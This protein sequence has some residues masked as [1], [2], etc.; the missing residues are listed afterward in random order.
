MW[1]T[2][3]RAD[4]SS[5]V[6]GIRSAAFNAFLP[7][8][9]MTQPIAIE[10]DVIANVALGENALATTPPIAEP[11][12]MKVPSTVQSQPRAATAMPCGRTASNTSQ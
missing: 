10:I 8:K 6:V 12:A 2:F 5:S 3:S 11:A 9:M 4:R 7:I 1:S